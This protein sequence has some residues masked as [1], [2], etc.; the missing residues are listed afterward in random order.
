LKIKQLETNG[1]KL[2]ATSDL[3]RFKNWMDSTSPKESFKNPILLRKDIR[4][5][6][7]AYPKVIDQQQASITEGT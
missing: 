1:E 5:L 4:F 3:E 7:L 6:Q 2:S